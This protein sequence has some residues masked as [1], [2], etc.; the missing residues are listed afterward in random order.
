MVAVAWRQPNIYVDISAFRPHH[1]A[2]H[3]SGWDM[4]WYYLSRT[5]QDKVPLWVDVAATRDA[6]VRGSRKSPIAMSA[7]G[8]RAQ[9][10]G[11]ERRRPFRD[12][13]SAWA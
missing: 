10:V 2:A 7:P 5:L 8:D 12:W 3:G 11:R 4:L 6:A 13:P 9:V 1:I